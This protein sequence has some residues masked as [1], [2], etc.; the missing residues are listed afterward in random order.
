MTFF[1]IG[2]LSKSRDEIDDIVWKFGGR[3]VDKIDQKLTAVLSN[4]AEV[5]RMGSLMKQA[6]KYNIQVVSE[7]FFTAIET[8]DPMFY[9]ISESLCEWGGDVSSALII[10]FQT[11]LKCLPSRF[12]S[13]GGVFYETFRSKSSNNLHSSEFYSG[14]VQI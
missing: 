1:I 8:T 10:S 11:N 3:L 13:S 7:E 2:T 9:I 5:R 14:L 12:H 4:Q 6:K